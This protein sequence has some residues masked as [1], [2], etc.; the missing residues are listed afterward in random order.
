MRPYRNGA[1]RVPVAEDLDEL[2]LL[3]DEP[4]G[5]Q[6][7]RPYRITGDALEFAQVHRRIDVRTG[8]RVAAPGLALQARQAPLQRHLPALVGRERG[9]ARAGAGALVAASRGLAASRARTAPDALARLLRAGGA[10]QFVESH[11]N[12][13]PRPRRGAAP[14]GP[15]PGSGACPGVPSSL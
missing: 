13:P 2:G 10:F 7:V 12:P 1:P 3:P 8:H 4:G 6:L 15:C 5:T 14:C 11:P 9:D